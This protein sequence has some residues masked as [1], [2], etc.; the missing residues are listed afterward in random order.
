LPRVPDKSGYLSE[1]TIAAIVTAVGGAISVLRISGRRAFEILEVLGGSSEAEARK[2]SRAVLKTRSGE[3]IDD[4]LVARFPNPNSFTGEDVVEFHVHGGSF[5]ASRLLEELIA[6]GARQ[7]LPGEFSFRAVRNGKMALSQ[8]EAISDLICASNEK[9]VSLALEKMAGSQNQMIGRIAEEI[10]QLA[11]LGEVGIDFSDQDVEEVSLRA[12]KRRL[13][14]LRETL[15]RLRGSFSRGSKIQDGVRVAFVGLPNAGKSSFFNAL[16]G[17]DRSIVSEVAGTTRDVIREKLTLK[18]KASSVTL[19]LEDLAGLRA[20]GDQ[21]EKIGVERTLKAAREADLILLVVDAAGASHEALKTEWEKLGKPTARSLGVLTK[22]DLAKTSQLSLLRDSLAGFGVQTWLE[23]S[24][25]TG[26]GIHEAA[27]RI[28][29]F[30]EKWTGRDPGEVLLT[31]LDHVQAVSEALEHL[32]RAEKASEIELFASDVRQALHALGP[33]IGETL[34]DDILGRI[35]S[36][37]CI[38]K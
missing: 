17:E 22:I 29:D 6:L 4:A 1:D 21:I 5:I 8:A 9:A 34:P 12:L 2:L 16:L 27:E 35:F 3:S 32:T 23:T 7:A 25:A 28:A 11:T 38:G 10:R 33:I 37:F 19:R 14:S 18:G 20:S 13:S 24:A 26:Q 30:C 15:E 36:N 31:R